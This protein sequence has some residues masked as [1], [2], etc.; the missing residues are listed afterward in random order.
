MLGLGRVFKS[1]GRREFFL[2]VGFDDD[3]IRTEKEGGGGG[4][5]DMS[6][7]FFGTVAEGTR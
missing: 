1:L 3:E 6:A 7:R 4:G 2:L 5:G